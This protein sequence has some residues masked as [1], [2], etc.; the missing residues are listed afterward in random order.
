[1]RK[2]YYKI[3]KFFSFNLYCTNRKCS[4]VK[5]QLKIEIEDGREAP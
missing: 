3:S 2:K 5:P 4:K 1:M